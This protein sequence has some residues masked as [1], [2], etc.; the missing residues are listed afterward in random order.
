MTQLFVDWRENSGNVKGRLVLVAFRLASAISR[1]PRNIRWLG[2]PYVAFYRILVEWFLGVELPWKLSVGS[3]LRVFHGQSL[4]VSDKA[5]I[6]KGCTLRNSTTIG[7]AE[8]A[9]DFS[10]SAPHIGDYVDVGANA[11]I[12]GGITVGS[13]AV[14]G[15]GSVV[16]KDVPPYATV[17]G[18]PARIVKIS[19]HSGTGA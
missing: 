10:G 14:I 13:Y 5:V 8:T 4:V 15:A 1:M 11:V 9:V 2:L 3:G 18:N 6:G 7:V 16:I 12:I 17:V 19:D